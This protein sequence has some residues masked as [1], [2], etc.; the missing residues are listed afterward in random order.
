M[1][2]APDAVVLPTQLAAVLLLDPQQQLLDALNLHD[3]AQ[4]DVQVTEDLLLAL[5]ADLWS[6]S[7]SM[8]LSLPPCSTLSALTHLP[9]RLGNHVKLLQDGIRGHS[10]LPV[11]DDRR[12]QHE[13]GHR[14][15]NVMTDE[16]SPMPLHIRHAH[17]P[18]AF[19]A[20]EVPARHEGWAEFHASCARLVAVGNLEHPPPPEELVRQPGLARTR[21]PN[22]GDEP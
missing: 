5:P 12:R 4:D 2:G 21:L 18:I 14:E 13:H 22:D 3:V 19:R 15:L 7:S 20:P 16:A 8:F 10:P 17:N 11:E 9:S 6:S 1:Q